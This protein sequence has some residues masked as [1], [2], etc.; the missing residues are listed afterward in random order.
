VQLFELSGRMILEKLVANHHAGDLQL[1]TSTLNSGV[2]LV[3]I[4]NGKDIF[5]HKVLKLGD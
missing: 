3:R 2:Y 5:T 4:T 1:N